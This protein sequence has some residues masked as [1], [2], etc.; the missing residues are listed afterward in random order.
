MPLAPRDSRVK[1]MIQNAIG[2]RSINT[3]MRQLDMAS[4]FQ[5]V[6]DMSLCVMRILEVLFRGRI[7]HR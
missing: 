3:N 1:T 5:Y 7:E 6:S 2:E 4:V